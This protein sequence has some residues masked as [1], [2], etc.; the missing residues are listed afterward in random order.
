MSKSIHWRAVTA[1]GSLLLICCQGAYGV[2]NISISGTVLLP[3]PCVVNP[4]G[5]VT[6]AFGNDLEASKINGINYSRPVS[7]T[8]ICGPQSTTS[9]TLKFTGAG[10]TF[11]GMVLATNKD[12]LGIRLKQG[13]SNWNRNATVNFTYPNYPVVT[14]VL[15]KR[16]GSTLTEGTFS[17]VA[18]LVAELR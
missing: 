1:L 14:A 6:V 7:Y 3:P 18:T 4:T 10:A 9:M 15:V 11:D 16:A 12:D 5:T 2:N 13:G 8:V 17:A